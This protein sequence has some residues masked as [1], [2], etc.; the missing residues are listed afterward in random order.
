MIGA[1]HFWLSSWT[2]MISKAHISVVINII[3]HNYLL[4][5]MEKNY[6]VLPTPEQRGVPL[7]TMWFDSLAFHIDRAPCPSRK[8]HIRWARAPDSRVH[9]TEE[10][11]KHWTSAIWHVVTQRSGSLATKPSCHFASGITIF[12]PD[13]SQCVTLES[14]SLTLILLNYSLDQQSSDYSVARQV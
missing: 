7:R 14:F 2:G 13:F 11:K 6:V 4:E 3:W 1:K 10:V 8:W 12:V 5:S 9:R